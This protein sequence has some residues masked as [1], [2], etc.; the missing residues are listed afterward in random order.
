MPGKTSQ[1][2]VEEKSVQAAS[3]SLQFW[4][5]YA[6]AHMMPHRGTEGGN[7]PGSGRALSAATHHFVG[8]DFEL[9][10]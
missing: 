1:V 5:A 7:A 3:H 6:S 4:H 2:A 10:W 9:H 8:F